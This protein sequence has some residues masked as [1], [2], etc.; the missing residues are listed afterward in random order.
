MQNGIFIWEEFFLTKSNIHTTYLHT[1]VFLY[2]CRY[3][4]M[5]AFFILFWIFLAR[6]LQFY[7]FAHQICKS[8]NSISFTWNMYVSLLFS[9]FIHFEKKKT[10]IVFHTKRKFPIEKSFTFSSIVWP[11]YGCDCNIEGVLLCMTRV[12]TCLTAHLRQ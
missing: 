1:Y 3:V 2:V 8:W 12:F 7:L 6:N 9:E 11:T 4:C 5:H 10:K